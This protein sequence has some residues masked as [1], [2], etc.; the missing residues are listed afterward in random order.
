[1]SRSGTRH[2]THSKEEEEGFS[3]ESAVLTNFFNRYIGRKSCWNFN[4]KTEEAKSFEPEE[5]REGNRKQKHLVATVAES[6]FIDYMPCSQW[7]ITQIASLI[8]CC[9]R[10]SKSQGEFCG[11]RNESRSTFHCFTLWSVLLVRFWLVCVFFWVV[12]CLCCFV[13][14]TYKTFPQLTLGST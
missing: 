9:W 6:Y 8:T 14:L 7:N 5:P 13:C 4:T 10:W 11:R 2:M 12:F 1:M 3:E